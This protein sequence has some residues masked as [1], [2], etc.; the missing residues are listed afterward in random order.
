VGQIVCRGR[1]DFLLFCKYSDSTTTGMPA[2]SQLIKS[3][4]SVLHQVTFTA[5][6]DGK[7]NHR[8]LV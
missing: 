8:Q 5:Y 7:E 1:R 4:K 2:F 3:V 6:S